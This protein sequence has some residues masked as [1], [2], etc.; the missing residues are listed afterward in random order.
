M[1]RITL[2]LKK[3]GQSPDDIEDSTMGITF[4]QDGIFFDATTRTRQPSTASDYFTGGADT[5]VYFSRATPL[6]RLSTIYS[7][8]HGGDATPLGGVSPLS[9]T[10]DIA[11]SRHDW[12]PEENLV[13]EE[14]E[15]EWAES[16]ALARLTVDEEIL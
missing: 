3:Q 12:A 2:H 8:R 11:E 16:C 15:R 5:G 6:R 10:R 1:S 9:E 7:S 13:P 4:S 14:P